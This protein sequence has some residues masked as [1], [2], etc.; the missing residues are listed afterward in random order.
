MEDFKRA[1][2]KVFESVDNPKA[3]EYRNLQ[4]IKDEKM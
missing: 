1:V 3:L 4:G 2:I